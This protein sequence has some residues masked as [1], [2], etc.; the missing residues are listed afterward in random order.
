MAVEKVEFAMS[1]VGVV[2]G[3]ALIVGCRRG[4]SASIDAFTTEITARYSPRTLIE[5]SFDR[6]LG[7]HMLLV[8]HVGWEPA[9]LELGKGS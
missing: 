2:G 9:S 7:D 4:I 6:R 5:A 3:G 1:D 8:S